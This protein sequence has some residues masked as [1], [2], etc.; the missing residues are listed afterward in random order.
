[1][2]LQIH[3]Q[4]QITNGNTNEIQIQI[5]KKI[6][7]QIQIKIQI[8]TCTL[9]N[10]SSTNLNAPANK[11]MLVQQKQMP[12]YVTIWKILL[13]ATNSTEIYRVTRKNVCQCFDAKIWKILCFLRATN[14]TEIYRVTQQMSVSVLTLESVLEVRFYIFTCFLESKV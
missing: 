6:Q 14:L 2:Q 11:Q 10:H 4:I 13:R 9:H 7:T 5:H 8:R 3:K 12:I 1:M